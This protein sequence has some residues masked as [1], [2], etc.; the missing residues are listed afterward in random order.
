MNFLKAIESIQSKNLINEIDYG[1][2]SHKSI[3]LIDAYL[4][5]T[6]LNDVKLANEILGDLHDSAN[7]RKLRSRINKKIIDVVFLNITDKFIE[8]ERLNKFVYLNKLQ[9]IGYALRSL[10]IVELG[11][12]I[13]DNILKVAAKYDASDL[14]YEASL[15]LFNHYAL[16]A[17]DEKK[18]KFY[19]AEMNF[20]FLQT[21]YLKEVKLLYGK[22]SHRILTTRVENYFFDSKETL[23]WFHTLMEYRNKTDNYIVQLLIFNMEASYYAATKDYRSIILSCENAEALLQKKPFRDNALRWHIHYYSAYSYIRLKEY[24]A[25]IEHFE[26]LKGFL[27]VGSKYWFIYKGLEFIRLCM[28]G[29]I[30]STF[31]LSQ[32]VFSIKNIKSYQNEYSIWLCRILFLKSILKMERFTKESEKYGN[33]LPKVNATKY[34]QELGDFFKDKVGMNIAL[35][36]ITILDKLIDN[37][38]DEVDDLIDSFSQYEY[39]YLKSEESFRSKC[40]IKMLKAMQKA[41]FHPARTKQ[42]SAALY[43]KLQT[44]DSEIKEVNVYVELIPFDQLWEFILEVLENNKNALSKSKLT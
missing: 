37:K 35:K 25:V 38:Y 7:I 42:L 26:A 8:D 30:S 41:Y 28:L 23:E 13:F 21:Q 32:E 17:P 27:S 2:Y 34:N 14:C 6:Q 12:T 1:F 31:E 19:E 11:N 5:N 33:L 10:N 15:V 36:T 39:K 16:S 44:K 29:Q 20:H 9:T 43:K 18:L 4:K 3:K 24:D 22:L 40:F